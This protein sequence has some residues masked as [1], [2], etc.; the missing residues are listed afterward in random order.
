V[1]EEEYT[2]RII[3]YFST[4]LLTLP[5][6]MTLRSYLADKLNCDPMRI[7]KK[8]AG[9]SCLGRRMF[10]FRDK[11][12]PNITQIQMAKA[13]LD[14]LEERFRRRVEEGR[15]GLPLQHLHHPMVSPFAMRS[16]P[17]FSSM[18]Q[19]P[20]LFGLH[21][22]LPGMPSFQVAPNMVSSTPDQWAP[23][24]GTASSATSGR[25]AVI[26]Q[27][28]Q[29]A[30]PPNA[31]NGANPA[32][33]Q[34]L[35]ALL[36]LLAQQQQQK[37]QQQQQ[38]HPPPP[39]PSQPQPLINLGSIPQL[40]QRLQQPHAGCSSY[41][42]SSVA[43]P[44]SVGNDLAANV[45]AEMLKNTFQHALQ[46]NSSSSSAPQDFKSTPSESSAATLTQQIMP[47]D[48]SAQR[49][50]AERQDA[51]HLI[52]F[53]S[54]LRRSYEDAL[55][56]NGNPSRKRKSS[57][58]EGSDS[59]ETE[60]GDEPTRPPGRS[61]AAVTDSASSSGK[62]E[63]SIDESDWNS[64]KKTDPSSSEDSDKDEKDV[65]VSSSKLPLRKRLKTKSLGTQ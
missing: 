30:P 46:V 47:N 29:P 55:S 2:S 22:T 34:V 36:P 63:S 32:L 7:T 58:D 20:W 8:Y 54:S 1:E 28:V 18:R 43:P 11:P 19:Q 4:G 25:S 51:G 52:G 15:P 10:Q 57:C 37:Q 62:P 27:E 60:S 61:V 49:S 35:A 17:V 24:L 26:P 21:A 3:H 16:D 31:S 48:A 53:L 44:S 14:L 12:Q 41:S 5:D 40:V 65:E 33:V 42:S 13:E 50:T 23:N 9:A 6:G 38:Q 64:D 45:Y 59:A 56:S 39:P